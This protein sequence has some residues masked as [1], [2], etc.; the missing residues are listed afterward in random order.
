VINF[1][2]DTHAYTN[3]DGVVYTSVTSLIKQY[4]LPFDPDGMI[5]A[6]VAK[7]RDCQVSDVLLEWEIKRTK[8][9]DKGN[10]LHLAIEKLIKKEKLTDREK[11]ITA[12]FALWK[13]EN[14]TG[15]LEPEKRLWNDFYEVAGTTDLVENYKHRVNIYDFKTNEEIRFVSKHNQYLL[16]ELSFL[17]DCEYNKY[18]LQLSLYARLV[19]ILDGRKP[20]KLTILWFDADYKPTPIPVPYMR[21][22]ADIILH[23]H[24]IN[25][26]S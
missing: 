13:K 15:K 20:G 1:Q 9:A 4:T 10:E 17:E 21:H 12:H 25:R 26:F 2:S 23:N 11:E 7:S 16:G 19:E 3:A 8:A 22:S 6:R 5:A 18:A 24:L 14:L